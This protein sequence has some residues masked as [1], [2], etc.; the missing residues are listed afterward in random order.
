M[1]KYPLVVRSVIRLLLA[2]LIIAALIFTKTLLVPLFFSVLLAYLL[3][4]A[5][6]LLEG[7]GLPRILTN[8]MLIVTITIIVI[9]SVYGM[10]LLVVTFT[11]DLPEIQEQI[12]Q[13]LNQFQQSIGSLVGITENRQDTMIQNA[14]GSTGHSCLHFFT[15]VL[16]EQI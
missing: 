15:S 6:E 14:V 9:G 11:S 4:P 3:Y 8:F 16:Q 1:Q 7:K 2:F 12:R 13:N 10:A 5:A